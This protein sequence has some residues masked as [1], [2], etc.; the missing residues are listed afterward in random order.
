MLHDLH[1]VTKAKGF[2]QE[3][4]EFAVKGNMIDLAVAVVVGTAFNKIVDSLVNDIIMPAIAMA[5]G[6]PD[7]SYFVVGSIKIGSFVNSLVNF[8]IV[9]LTIFVTIKVVTR[10]LPHR[11]VQEVV[12]APKTP[13]QK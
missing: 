2:A 12:V 8:L 7:F 11:N 5:F 1:P 9:A 6:K 10:L 4:K 3:F 13:E